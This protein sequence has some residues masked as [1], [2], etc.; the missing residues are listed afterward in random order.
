MLFCSFPRI[1]FSKSVV[2]KGILPLWA[3][4]RSLSDHATKNQGNMN[5]TASLIYTAD[6]L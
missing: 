6:Q 2:I 1:G 3:F 4:S 5:K